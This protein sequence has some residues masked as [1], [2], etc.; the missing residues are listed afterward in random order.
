[1]TWG[2]A[3]F[4][5]VPLLHPYLSSVWFTG[6]EDELVRNGIATAVLFDATLIVG[7]YREFCDRSSQKTGL[8]NR[9]VVIRFG[10]LRKARADCR[11]HSVLPDTLY[12]LR[13]KAKTGANRAHP[14]KL[15]LHQHVLTIAK[16]VEFLARDVTGSIRGL[17]EE[18]DVGAVLSVSL[19]LCRSTSRRIS[20]CPHVRRDAA[21]TSLPD[22]KDLLPLSRKANGW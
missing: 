15:Q 8:S 20:R 5:A 13:R 19:V 2:C 10:A 17:N 1:M 9:T 4:V 7:A 6:F 14:A 16:L 11:R 22:A 3:F 18:N 12:R 21:G